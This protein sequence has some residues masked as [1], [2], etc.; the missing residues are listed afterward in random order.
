MKK[1]APKPQPPQQEQTIV[2][3]PTQIIYADKILN[4]AIGAGVSKLTL[5]MEVK[6]NTLSPFAQLVL[7]TPAMFEALEFF[8]K[9]ISS[10]DNLKANIIE[11]LDTFKGTLSKSP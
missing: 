3:S 10:D 5:A 8:S 6:E 9:T 4:I 11:A 1:S 2:G 7:P